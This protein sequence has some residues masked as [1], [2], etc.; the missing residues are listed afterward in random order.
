MANASLEPIYDRLNGV[1]RYHP[2]SAKTFTDWASEAGDTV[3]IS[4]EGTVYTAP[5]HKQSLV[6]HGKHMINMESTGTKERTPIE[7]MSNQ[8]ENETSAGMS[9]SRGYGGG[10]GK[11]IKALQYDFYDEDGMYQSQLYMDEQRFT[12][13]FTKTGIEGLPE[14]TTLMTRINQ[15]AEE[16]SLE[17]IRARGAENELSSRL[18]VTAEE[19]TAEVTRATSAESSISGRLTVEA[20]KI[21]QIV[22]AVGANG[23]VTAA[24]IV[25]AIN[26]STGSSEAKIDADH[27]YIGNSKSTTIINGKCSLSDVTASYISSQLLNAGHITVNGM[28]VV[29]DLYVSTGQHS[30]NVTAAIWDLNIAQSG[31]TY[32]LQRKRMSD[33]SWVDVGTFSRATTLSG[34]WSGGTLTVS[35]SPQGNTFTADLFTGGHWGYAPGETWTTYYGNVS[36]KHNGGSTSYSTGESYTVNALDIFKTVSVTKQGSAESVY[37]PDAEGTK[38]YVS[39]GS[40]SG[41]RQGSAGPKLALYNSS[42]QL[43][44]Q[45]SSGG[46][47][48][49]TSGAKSWYYNNT[50]GTQY[51]LAGSTYAYSLRSGDG[52]SLSTAQRYKAGSSTTYYERRT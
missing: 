5:V 7:R 25:L 26:E 2:F 1:Q 43:Y 52:I 16:I 36:A 42:I 41:T 19:I 29:G 13:I 24:S 4:R 27:V 48:P 32:T 3:Q 23:Q 44:Y 10:A 6:W 38:Y 22:S 34:A 17:A 37:V 18:T 31:N 51:Y 47:S 11:A 46:Y 8:K 33:G 14:G 20:G 49:A 30:Q 9:S 15:N 21:T 45:N 35:A 28:T 39:G 50:N 40:A 12:T